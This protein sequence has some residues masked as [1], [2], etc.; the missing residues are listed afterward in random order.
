MEM[1]LWSA[2]P[3]R[4]LSLQCF[5]LANLAAARSYGYF[6]RKIETLR[7]LSAFNRLS[8]ERAS[9]KEQR[10]NALLTM[11]CQQNVTFRTVP[12]TIF[13]I[14]RPAVD[15]AEVKAQGWPS[16]EPIAQWRSSS[17]KAVC[18]APQTKTSESSG[19]RQEQPETGAR[20][21]P[22]GQSL[23]APSVV[24]AAAGIGVRKAAPSRANR[25]LPIP[26]QSETISRVVG[27][28]P[29]S[30]RNPKPVKRSRQNWVKP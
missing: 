25:D 12:I 10:P 13:L 20:H 14:G 16:P 9:K 8:R 23:Q 3:L 22:T 11:R 2:M 4:R 15:A 30:T 1:Y 6:C 27:R 28:E 21:D 19:R 17:R 24:G 29:R 5:G 26:L 18:E 7:L